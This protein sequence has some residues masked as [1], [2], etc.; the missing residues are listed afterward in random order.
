M[1]F[2][3]ILL[4]FM[5]ANSVFAVQQTISICLAVNNNTFKNARFKADFKSTDVFDNWYAVENNSSQQTCTRHTYQ[6]GPKTL[7]YLQV[8]VE[9]II[10]ARNA[11]IIP[12]S[13][14]HF[15]KQTMSSWFI[16]QNLHTNKNNHCFI[17][18]ITQI[19]KSQDKYIYQMRCAHEQSK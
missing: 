2:L 10:S 18:T 3:I 19:R 17:F 1:R 5:F 7:K 16:K 6:H 12:D 11:F 8:G 15:V 4:V 14:C 13:S 9:G